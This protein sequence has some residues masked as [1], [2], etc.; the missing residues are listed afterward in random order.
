VLFHRILLIILYSLTILVSAYLSVVGWEYYGLDTKDRPHHELHEQW[1]P[2]GFISHGA[3]VIGSTLM[4]I[5]LLYSLRK[6][7][8]IM[9]NWGNIRQ[10]LNYHIWMGI[11]G[12]ILVLFHTTFKFGGI[13]AVSFWSMVAVALSGVLGRYIY[14]QIPR[15]MSGN[16]LT[17]AEMRE[18]EEDL[19]E[20]IKYEAAGN[21]KALEIVQSF[22]ES[23]ER[24]SAR[25]GLW[26]WIKRDL[27]E[28]FRYHTLSQ[29]L[30]KDL[31]SSTVRVK[32]LIKLAR[33]R[34]RLG[35]R[36]LF[37]NTARKLLHHWHIFHKPFAAV[38]IL[39]MIVHVG[40][41]IT[42]GYVWI[43]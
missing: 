31:K 34:A 30:R 9:Q 1:K 18:L 35:R 37:L 21:E 40:V 23:E 12:P 29:N 2:S 26:N 8:R 19:Q 25:S 4:L 13:V 6:R 15:S 39:I 20:Q 7:L 16:E 43:F 17:A 28:P 32:D 3:G 11:T 36:V 5:L 24:V 38:M 27:G 14:V 42:L 41:A 33:K 22:F 10:W